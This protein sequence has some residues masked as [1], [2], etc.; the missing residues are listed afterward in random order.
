M[1]VIMNKICIKLILVLFTVTLRKK[2]KKLKLSQII[3]EVTKAN[4]FFKILNLNVKH[5]Q[6]MGTLSLFRS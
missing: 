6:N 1:Y 3:G 2:Y 5:I 4:Y